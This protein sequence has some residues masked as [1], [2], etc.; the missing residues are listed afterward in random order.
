MEQHLRAAH[1][2]LHELMNGPMA[3]S[4]GCMILHDKLKEIDNHVINALEKC[5]EETGDYTQLDRFIADWKRD[6]ARIGQ[7]R[8]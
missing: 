1:R 8:R 7:D 5:N 3:W 6:A 4:L 2:L